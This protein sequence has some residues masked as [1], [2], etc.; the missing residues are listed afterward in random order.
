[1]V[2]TSINRTAYAELTTRAQQEIDEGRLP[3]CQLA[4]ARNGELLAFETLG[5]ATNETRYVV[6]SATKGFMAG[7]VWL[8]IGDGA[9][10]VSRKVV[11]YFPEFGANGKDAVTVEQMLTYK[12]G[13]PRAPMGPETWKDRSARVDRMASWRLTAE[14]GTRYEYATTANAWVM[15]EIV[16]RITGGDYRTLMTERISGPLG[17]SFRLGVPPSEQG[18]I[19]RIEQR[20]EPA[21]SGEFQAALGVPA[22]NV[23]EVT[24]AALESFNEPRHLEAGVP[25]AGGVGTA[26]DLAMYYQALLHNIGG[27]WDPDILADGTGNI[28]V[29]DPDMLFGG[30][31]A[32]RTLGLLVAGDDGKGFMRTFGHTV[33]ARA[34]GHP[35]AAGQ[36]AWADPETGLSFGFVTNGI[37]VHLLRQFRRGVSLASK[38]GNCVG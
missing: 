37:D 8:L 15:A 29:S 7:L 31:P 6:Y 23:G 3:S 1:M 16:D 13:F 4:L 21:T 5:V 20:G 17:F 19:A 26:A 24:D 34:F 14:P 35:G 32:N 18:D 38:A 12:S 9:L 27:L 28:R 30:I 25:G 10:D 22:I 33:S 11:D 36:L 2:Q